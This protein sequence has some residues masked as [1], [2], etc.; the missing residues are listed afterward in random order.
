MFAIV[1]TGSKQFKV[2]ANDV[3]LVEK[4]NANAG[5]HIHLNEVLLIGNGDKVTFGSPLI[6]GAIVV[7]KVEGQ[8]R[9]NKVIVFKKKRRKNYRRK[10]G[11]RQCQ[12]TLRIV[13]IS[14]DGKVS[15]P[16]EIHKETKVAAPKAEKAPAKKAAVAKEAKAPAAKKPA[17]AKKTTA[18][19]K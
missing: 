13:E 9:T 16:K 18:K 3:I 1:R 17:A 19:T 4:I 8:Q 7:A 14:A 15:A 6:K 2:K 11:H 5:D 12:T 10:N